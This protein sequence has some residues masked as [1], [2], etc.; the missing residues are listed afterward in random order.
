MAETE[1][2]ALV[3]AWRKEA[4]QLRARYGLD[5][6]AHVCEAH[7]SELAAAIGRHLAEQLTLKDASAL[8][9]YSTSHLRALIADGTLTNAGR[10][11]SPRL[12]RGE[13]PRKAPV[14]A[15]ASRNR[16]TRGFDA[17]AAAEAAVTRMRGKQQPR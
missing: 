10:K 6:L 4:G 15:P 8:S 17:A 12:L 2:N 16:R 9:G 14:S 5:S 3:T 7:A 11:G 1:L 13:L